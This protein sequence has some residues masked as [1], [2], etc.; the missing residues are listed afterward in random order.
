MT[1]AYPCIS[2]I[3]GHTGEPTHL[4]SSKSKALTESDNLKPGQW[5]RYAALKQPYVATG[6]DCGVRVQLQVNAVAH[7]NSNMRLA[8]VFI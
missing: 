2:A 5:I 8:V 7:S 1:H 6:A 3:N 4:A